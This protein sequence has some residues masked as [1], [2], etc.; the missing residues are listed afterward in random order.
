MQQRMVIWRY[1]KGMKLVVALSGGVDSVVLLHM[2]VEAREHEIVVAHFDHGVRP[3]SAADARFVEQLA[4][5]YGL[6]YETRREELGTQ[7]S[8][9]L[10]RERRYAFLHDV[11]ERHDAKLVTAHHMGD[12]VET[13]A[14][15]ISRGTRWKGL[16]GMSDERVWRPLINRTKSELIAYALE[17]RLEWCED[18]TNRQNDYTRN[19]LRKQLAVL[20]S[21][22]H[23]RVYELWSRQHDLRREIGREIERGDFPVLSRYFVT[24]IERDVARELLHA[25]IERETGVSLLGSQLDYLLLAV[26]TGRPQ[27]QWQ[28]GQGVTIGLDV[29][30]WR[31]IPHEK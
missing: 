23:W 5:G 8:E 16:A 14:L 7:S 18:E 3:D 9:E 25:H 15:N 2:L 11:A 19:R 17:H 29:K 1:T 20:P 24:M 27:T 10:A 6:V 12:V 4:T 22:V 31:V 21:H 30:N 28:V 26:R 13:V